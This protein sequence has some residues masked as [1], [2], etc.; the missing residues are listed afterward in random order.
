MNAARPTTAAAKTVTEIMKPGMSAQVSVIINETESQLLI[1]RSAVRFEGEAAH[2]VRLEAS[3]KQNTQR[4]IAVTILGADAL[5]Y[6][7]ATGGALKEGDRIL[8]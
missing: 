5:N 1:P 7:V 3:D 6:V 4:Q 8:R 2:V